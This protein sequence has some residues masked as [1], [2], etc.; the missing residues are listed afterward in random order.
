[1][2]DRGR[3]GQRGR[4]AHRLDQEKVAPPDRAALP[5]FGARHR[6]DLRQSRQ[7]HQRLP[8]ARLALMQQP[9]SQRPE[10]GGAKI[11]RIEPRHQ[12]MGAFH[13]HPLPHGQ[14]D[15]VRAI[16]R[17]DLDRIPG[18]QAHALIHSDRKG[19]LT[20]VGQQLRAVERQRLGARRRLAGRDRPAKQPHLRPRRG[21]GDGHVDPAPVAQRH[22]RGHGASGVQRLAVLRHKPQLVDLPL[23]RQPVGSQRQPTQVNAFDLIQ[24]LAGQSRRLVARMDAEAVEPA[25]LGIAAQRQ[26]GRLRHAHI[27]D[28]QLQRP[29]A[30]LGQRQGQ[31]DRILTFHL[32]AQRLRLSAG[33]AQGDALDAGWRAALEQKRI[34]PPRHQR[35]ILSLHAPAARV[36]QLQCE[37]RPV[38]PVKA[39]LPVQMPAHRT[40]EACRQRRPVHQHI[41]APVRPRLDRQ[42]DRLAGRGL[43][44]QLH[45][46]G[47]GS[48]I[49]ERGAFH[50]QDSAR[51]GGADRPFGAAAQSGRAVRLDRGHGDD[52]HRLGLLEGGRRIEQQ[53]HGIVAPHAQ[54]R[55]IIEFGI[56]ERA[57]DA[58]DVASDADIGAV[59]AVARFSR[60]A[61]LQRQVGGRTRQRFGHR[62]AMHVGQHQRIAI[63]EQAGGLHLDHLGQAILVQLH[64]QAAGEH[65]RERAQ[66]FGM[67]IFLRLD[68]PHEAVEPRP[69]ERCLVEVLR[70]P[71]ELARLAAHRIA[72]RAFRAARVGDEEQHHL[73]RALGHGQ[74]QFP[75]LGLLFPG[76]GEVNPV[77]GWRIGRAAQKGGHQ[78]EARALILGQVRLDR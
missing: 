53:A 57:E 28:L 77:L 29:R 1:M 75:V 70:R 74:R 55:Q 20:I 51:P 19:H 63:V 8:V 76:F 9:K 17:R 50:R 21:D 68:R 73:P 40:A 67:G 11:G 22:P 18:V 25:R 44:R 45:L 58:R 4:A 24:T 46:A 47:I 61:Q 36:G 69:V 33:C 27:F 66:I 78:D 49:D 52:H 23:A 60:G 14:A 13:P 37:V 16:G 62:A 31:R 2:R 65:G 59:I 32:P 48:R 5:L 34:I 43:E 39:P 30:A 26:D 3:I 72:Q 38:E 56:A 54:G 35:V 41:A 15:R 42:L 71:H 7:R 10:Q 64:R 6:L 12:Y